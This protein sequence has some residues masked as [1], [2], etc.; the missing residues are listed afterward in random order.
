MLH[1]AKKLPPAPA[2][3]LAPLPTRKPTE[4]EPLDPETV[5]ACLWHARGNIHQAARLARVSTARLGLFLKNNP[6][7][8]EERQRAAELLLDKAETVIDGLLDDADR[9]EDTAKWLLTQA[10][11]A[12]GYGKEAP[13]PMGFSFG[14][15]TGSGQIAIRWDIDG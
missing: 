5:K 10:G 6:P 9:Q 12:R 15:A 8:Q 4:D 14:T 11:K 1:K 13:A 3:G 2:P 7:L